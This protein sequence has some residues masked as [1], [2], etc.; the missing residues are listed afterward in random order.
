VLIFRDSAILIYFLD[1]T[2]PLQMRAASRLAALQA[3]ADEIAVSD[4]IR[5]EC[6]IVPLRAGDATRLAVFDQFFRHPSVRILPLTTAVLDRATAIR[7][8]HGFRTVDAINL[9]TAT[10]HGCDRFLTNDLQLAR[11]PDIVVEILP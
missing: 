4:L 11:F 7:A 5:M 1:H 9:A 8:Q 3:A 6:R 2:G 10:E